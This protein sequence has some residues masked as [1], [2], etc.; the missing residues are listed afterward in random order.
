MSGALSLHS[1]PR[2][3]SSVR[4]PAPLPAPA[5][6]DAGAVHACLRDHEENLSA[7]CKAYESKLEA[8]EHEDVRLNPQL[9]SECP[10]AISIYCSNVPGGEGVAGLALL[11]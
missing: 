6:D 1:P 3:V 7:D 2:M 4:C 5:V 10:L 9:M 11:C 8:M